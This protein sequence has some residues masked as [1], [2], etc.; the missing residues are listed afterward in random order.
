M[1]PDAIVVD[2]EEPPQKILDWARENIGENPETKCQ[3]ICELRDLIYGK[4]FF[5]FV[6]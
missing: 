2:L 5:L 1:D 4:D 3:L 6:L